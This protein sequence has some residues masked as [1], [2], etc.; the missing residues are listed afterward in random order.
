M[1][2]LQISI[3]STQKLSPTRYIQLA[4]IQKKNLIDH[5]YIL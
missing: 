5:V 2:N 4:C 1:S 3:I